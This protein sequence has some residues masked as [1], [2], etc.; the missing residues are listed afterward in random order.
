[1]NK[2]IAITFFLLATLGAQN[3]CEAEAT[4]ID[5][6]AGVGCYIPQCTDTCEWEAMQCWG[7]TGTCWCEYSKDKKPFRITEHVKCP[8]RSI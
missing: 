5:E 1:M 3:C 4:A 7:S 8:K 6:C 2:I